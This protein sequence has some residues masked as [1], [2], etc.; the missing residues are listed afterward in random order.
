MERGWIAVS[1][2]SSPM[3]G[4]TSN[5]NVKA[6]GQWDRRSRYGI[7][8]LR[9]S[10]AYSAA[11]PVDGLRCKWPLIAQC[12]ALTMRAAGRPGCWTAAHAQS[13]ASPA[14]PNMGALAMRRVRRTQ[15]NPGVAASATT[16]T[17]P[18]GTSPSAIVLISRQYRIPIKFLGTM[19]VLSRSRM[20]AGAARGFPRH[21]A[22]SASEVETRGGN[23]RTKWRRLMRS[24]AHISGRS[25]RAGPAT[26]SLPRRL[27]IQIDRAASR[28]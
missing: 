2:S 15:A 12:R 4:G 22:L 14:T 26:P 9:P 11:S 5:L 28:P 23:I 27:R 19:S 6:A 18:A 8:R 3:T 17:P 16:M 10:R 21:A 20:L 1:A 24:G 7:E 25:R 13:G